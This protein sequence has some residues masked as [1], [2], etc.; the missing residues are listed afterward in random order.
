MRTMNPQPRAIISFTS[1]SCALVFIAIFLSRLFLLM[2]AGGSV[3]FWDQWG[4]ENSIFSAFESGSLTLAQM[5]APHNEHR[6]FWTRLLTIILFELNGHQW[7]NQ[8]EAFASNFIYSISLTIP[9]LITSIKSHKNQAISVAVAVTLMGI[10]PFGWENTL[11]GFQSQFYIN[12]LLAFIAIAVSSFGAIKLRTAIALTILILASLASMA[13]GVL[14]AFACAGVLIARGA[15]QRDL[16]NRGA[17]LAAFVTLLGIAGF[18]ITPSPAYHAQLKAQDISEAAS[19]LLITSSWPLLPG[20]G[21][22]ALFVPAAFWMLIVGRNRQTQTDYFFLGIN[23][24]GILNAVAIA[25]SRGHGLAE[26]TSRYTDTILPSSIATIYFASRLIG[27]GVRGVSTRGIS[28]GSYIAVVLGIFCQS[29]LQW[30]KLEER[31]YWLRMS[32][33]NTAKFLAGDGG[34]FQGKPNGHVP[35]PDPA[36]LGASLRNNAQ[37]ESLPTSLL[38]GL[39]V[40]GRYPAIAERCNVASDPKDNFAKI[41][42]DCSF[43]AASDP[44]FVSIATGPLSTALMLFRQKANTSIF[45]RGRVIPTLALNTG[46]CAL[47]T[48]NERPAGQLPITSSIG[49]PIRLAGWTTPTQFNFKNFN[50]SE[51]RIVLSDGAQAYSFDTGHWRINRPDVADFFKNKSYMY[52][53]FDVYIDPQDLKPGTYRIS[54]STN[55]NSD[56][57]TG[58]SVKIDA[59]TLPFLRF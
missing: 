28:Y 10:L 53:G 51:L 22:L 3:P 44:N 12:T 47:D 43:P 45:P 49:L 4:G 21:Q 26:V 29:Y 31:A 16:L 14:T 13:N 34:A 24:L 18:I 5:F 7:D 48:F 35:Y 46:K 11:V 59:P 41:Q 38:G 55:T 40:S 42:A 39:A 20:I 54:V 32:T 33:L 36:H 58:H 50:W 8:V 52:S 15:N 25:Y 17:M 23:A 27:S 19:A 57:D 56:C 2:S 6:I 37:I 9:V 30:P 1:K